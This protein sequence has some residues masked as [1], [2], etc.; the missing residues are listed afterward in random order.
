MPTRPRQLSY[1]CRPGSG[2]TNQ[3]DRMAAVMDET[4]YV[5]Q[6]AGSTAVAREISEGCDGYTFAYVYGEAPLPRC[7]LAACAFSYSYEYEVAP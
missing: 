5:C 1:G 2:V 3:F 7:L 6:H 4:T